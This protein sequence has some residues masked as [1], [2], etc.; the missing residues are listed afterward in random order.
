MESP[1]IFILVSDDPRYGLF[2]AVN[3]DNSLIDK[4]DTKLITKELKAFL[5]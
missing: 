5:L 4:K 1:I 3:L 2:H